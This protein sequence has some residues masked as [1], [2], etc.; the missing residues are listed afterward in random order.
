MLFWIDIQLI[1][2][3]CHQFSVHSLGCAQISWTGVDSVNFGK[4]FHGCILVLKHFPMSEFKSHFQTLL[5]RSWNNPRT[6]EN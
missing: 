4:P 2:V 1:V 5:A 3:C 6:S